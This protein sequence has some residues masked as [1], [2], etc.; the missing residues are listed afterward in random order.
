MCVKEAA[1]PPSNLDTPERVNVVLCMIN[2]STDTRLRVTFPTDGGI[3][4]AGG[5]TQTHYVVTITIYA[6]QNAY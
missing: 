2:D 3:W 4:V 1:P 6:Y 5:E